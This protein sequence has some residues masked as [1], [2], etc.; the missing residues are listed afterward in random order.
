MP[1]AAR[2]DPAA[3]RRVLEALR[4]MAQ[5]ETVR[6][7]LRFERGTVGAALDQRGAR[8]FVDLPHL[9]HLA[10]IDRDRALVAVA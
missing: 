10:Q 6:L 8:R 3:E 9:A 1:A 4:E 2:R 7:E 5:R